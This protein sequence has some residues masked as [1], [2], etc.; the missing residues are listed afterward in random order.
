M[1]LLTRWECGN[2]AA[3]ARF[4]SAVGN[5]LWE[6][7]TARHFHCVGFRF[8]RSGA[9]RPRSPRWSLPNLPSAAKR[10]LILDDSCYGG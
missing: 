2:R 5:S 10:A 6:F 1:L 3:S 4:P 9:T 7:H 8:A